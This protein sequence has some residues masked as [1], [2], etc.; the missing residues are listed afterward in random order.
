MS[1]NARTNHAIDKYY[2]HNKTIFTLTIE[3]INFL[4]N[5]NLEPEIL[6]FIIDTC[7]TYDK[8]IKIILP[9]NIKKFYFF[10]NYDCELVNNLPTQIEEFFFVRV[11]APIT[12]LPINLKKIIVLFKVE[13]ALQNYIKKIPFGCKVINADDRIYYP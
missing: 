8:F 12:N 4:S 6:E 9:P 3:S 10:L 7:I 13:D 2:S 11:T 5:V 1:S